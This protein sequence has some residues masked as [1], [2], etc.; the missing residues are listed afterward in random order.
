MSIVGLTFEETFFVPEENHR[1]IKFEEATTVF[2]D[3]SS[4]T[5]YDPNHPVQENRYKEQRCVTIGNSIR[6]RL[7]VVVHED[8]GNTIRILRARRATLLE[9][10]E[11]DVKL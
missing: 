1:R 11:Y 7:V 9:K 6:Y 5:I 4:L 10:K 3:P 2:A 8:K